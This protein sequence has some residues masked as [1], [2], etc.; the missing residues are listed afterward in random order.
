MAKFEFVAAKGWKLFD[1]TPLIRKWAKAGTR[2]EGLMLRFA[3]EDIGVGGKWS[4][5]EFVS[6]EGPAGR[7]PMLLVID[8][9]K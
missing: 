6:R 5:Y 4:G 1:V 2:G 7:R 8:P 3:R 9:A